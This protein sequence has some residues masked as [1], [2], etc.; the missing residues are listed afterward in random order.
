MA[1]RPSAREIAEAVASAPPEARDGLTRTLERMREDAGYWLGIVSVATGEDR[2]AVDFLERVT[3]G[4]HPQGRW[5]DAARVN[6]AGPLVALGRI[7][8]A[9]RL[10]RTDE[11]PQRFGSRLRAEAL[12]P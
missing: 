3:L 4:E 12:R 10:L 1:S 2:S 7:E 11:S 9:A 5:T 6:L 8:E